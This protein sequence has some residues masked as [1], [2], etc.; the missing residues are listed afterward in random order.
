MAEADAESMVRAPGDPAEH[1]HERGDCEG[2]ERTHAHSPTDD[3]SAT[4]PRE[5]RGD[6]LLCRRLFTFQD[7][8]EPQAHSPLRSFVK[9]GDVLRF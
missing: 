4:G 1:I 3:G 6:D 7:S 8:A 5:I 9:T 2:H